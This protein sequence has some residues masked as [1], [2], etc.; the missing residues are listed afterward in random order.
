MADEISG[1]V[2]DADLGM[3]LSNSVA[4]DTFTEVAAYFVM[5]TSLL[6]SYSSFGHLNLLLNKV[7][8]TWFYIILF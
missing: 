6:I 4:R 7:V 5:A 1:S 3:R 8:I 2:M